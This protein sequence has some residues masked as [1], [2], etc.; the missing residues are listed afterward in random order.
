MEVIVADLTYN[1]T[2]SAYEPYA[3]AVRPYLLRADTHPHIRH[4][5]TKSQVRI[6]IDL[7][8]RACIRKPEKEIKVKLEHVASDLNVD[9]KTVTRA[10]STF[11]SLGWLLPNPEYDGRNRRGRFAAQQYI[12]SE[13]FRTLIG[14]PTKATMT[15][16]RDVENEHSEA[17]AAPASTAAS[18]TEMSHGLE[19]VNKSL[20]K[21]EAS[22]NKE[23]EK[24]PGLPVD[25]RPMQRELRIEHK[26]MCALMRLAKE[27]GQRLQDVW[28]VKKHLLVGSEIKGGRA[29]NY[30]KALLRSGDDFAYVAR[31]RFA[32]PAA[33]NGSS[34]QARASQAP[35]RRPSGL[36][37]DRKLLEQI[38]LSSRFKRYKHISKDM[39]VRLYDGTADV[40][41]G[42]VRTSYDESQMEGIYRG[43]AAGN[44]VEA[45]D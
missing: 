11:F 33:T 34:R 30:L 24:Q 31:T 27:L 12:I 41:H 22:F 2:L 39:V 37:I 32:A 28:H 29:V 26:G 20:L 15:R 25:L 19:G 21:K 45:L 42:A 44:L 8:S 36:P 18:K 5:L 35:Q 3:K 13:T 23:A 6:L 16:D 43:I 14:M 17:A 4:V 1:D 7:V 10:V 9:R 40:I 38:A